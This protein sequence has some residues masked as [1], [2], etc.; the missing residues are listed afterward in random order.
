MEQ[1][2]FVSVGV[3]TF[4]IRS[5]SMSEK[6]HH[7]HYADPAEVLQPGG[8]TKAVVSE[9]FFRWLFIGFGLLAVAAIVYSI[10]KQ[11]S[12]DEPPGSTNSVPQSEYRP[13]AKQDLFNQTVQ[14][15]FAI[16]KLFRKVYT[17]GWEGANGAIGDAYLYAATR[18]PSLLYSFVNIH[19]LTDMFN[20][21]WVDDRAWICLAEM[22]WWDFTGRTNTVWVDDAKRRYLEAKSEGRLAHPEGFWSWYNWSPDAKVNDQILTN[23]N[24]NQMA[25]AACWLYEATHEKQFYNDALLVWDGDS[26]YPGVEKKFYKGNGIWEGKSGR[27]AFGEQFPW[28]GTGICPLGAALYKMTGNLKYKDIVVATAKRAMDPVNGWVDGQDFY[29]IR[30]DGNGAFVDNVLT[31]Y[32]IAPDQLSDI[33]GKVER[34]L[35]HVWTN[36]HGRAAVT[37][38][39]A[40]DDGIRNGWNPNGGEDGYGV[41]EVGTVHAQ[42]QAV[43]AFGAFAYVLKQKME[44]DSGRG[45]SV[46]GDSARTK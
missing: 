24:M 10:V 12:A 22:Y 39:R 23:S 42:S 25:T 45:R 34:M 9:R 15:A 2:S 26:Q 35:E 7:K 31:A 41:G 1:A 16:D 27:A 6:H 19:K 13:L 8:S 30:M 32:E 43:R 38:H 14:R 17:A 5:R 46:G 28:M 44:A 21:T 36:R 3:Y 11:K 18:D 4:G 40:G 33:P 37:L 29:Q 20:G